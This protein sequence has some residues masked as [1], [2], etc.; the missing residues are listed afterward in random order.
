MQ[1]A[2]GLNGKL[3]DVVFRILS[4]NPTL[5][6]VDHTNHREKLAFDVDLL[7]E[8][9]VVAKE[10]LRRIVTEN[11]YRSTVLVF[12][13]GKGAAFL[14]GEAV[15]PHPFGF[16]AFQDGVLYGLAVVFDRIGSGAKLGK[17]DPDGSTHRLHMRQINHGMHIVNGEFLAG[18]NLFGGPTE[19]ED[20]KTKCPDHIRPQLRNL[21]GDAPIQSV[22]HRRNKD[23]GGDADHDTQYRERGAE[24]VGAQG[25]QRHIDDFAEISSPH[26]KYVP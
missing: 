16:N 15:D 1:L 26:H 23:D 18:A 6:L 12:G 4:T 22:D 11:D 19:A 17:K 21:V 10:F 9:R 20:I 7:A 2:E 25:G 14:H 5:A 8:R 13:I 24:F 3:D